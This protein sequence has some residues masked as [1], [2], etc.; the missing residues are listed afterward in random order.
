MPDP[1]GPGYSSFTSATKTLRTRAAILTGTLVRIDA[2]VK[3]GSGP[4]RQAKDGVD[5]RVAVEV[6]VDRGDGGDQPGAPCG[7]HIRVPFDRVDSLYPAG[8]SDD[9]SAVFFVEDVSRLK[10]QGVP[11]EDVLS[12]PGGVGTGGV[13]GSVRGRSPLQALLPAHDIGV[14]GYHGFELC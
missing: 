12:K 9:G 14:G 7:A 13:V 5:V 10:A 2:L 8:P 1:P 4:C 11:G 6:V 3:I